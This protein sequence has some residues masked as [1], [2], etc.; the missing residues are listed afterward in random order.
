MAE[1][2]AI[3]VTQRIY[4]SGDPRKKT[5]PASKRNAAET[6]FIRI[7]QTFCNAARK[8]DGPVHHCYRIGGKMVRFCFAGPALVPLLT[9]AFAHL[10]V[11]SNK[12]PSLTVYLWDSASTGT[13]L[14]T[15]PWDVE[16]SGGDG[17]WRFR[18][19]RFIIL[20]DPATGT[21]NMLDQRTVKAFFWTKDA[22]N[23]PT[24]EQGSP[25]LAI[26]HWWTVGHGL[27]LVHA[28]AV[29]RRDGGVI[30]VGKGGSGKSTT[31]LS[32]LAADL[33]YVSDDY[34]LLST[35]PPLFVYSIYSSG[36]VNM[37]DTYRFPFLKPSLRNLD[38]NGREKA[39]YFIHKV[40]RG[41]TT[42]GFP[43]KAILMPRL[44]NSPET[45]LRPAS[46]ASALLAMA[47]STVF[48]LRSGGRDTFQNLSRA[49]KSAPTYILEIGP[50][51]SR[52][53]EIISGLLDGYYN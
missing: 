30:L 16:T 35:H 41:K 43:L 48:Q 29:G 21:A 18:D 20:S 28:A 53:R 4:M 40:L 36:K 39:I 7:N 6:Y 32:C 11:K 47:P 9:P 14:P 1:K 42:A 31:A 3:D 23:L 26:L 50:D 27:Q 44:S 10:A 25:L 19:N 52:V 8:T 2:K 13:D 46:A 5:S 45:T 49:V 15:P 37:E 22:R 51:L 17:V 33:L 38:E 34:C 24:Y 12:A